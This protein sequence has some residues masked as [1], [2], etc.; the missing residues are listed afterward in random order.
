MNDSNTSNKTAHNASQPCVDSLRV[1]VSIFVRKGEQSLWENGIYQNCLFLVILLLRA[2]NVG[3]TYLV[4]GGGD[5]DI[6][7]AQRFMKDSPVPIIDMLTAANELDVMIEMSAQLDRNWAISFRE[8]GGK[9]VTMRVG[10][11]YVIDIERMIFDKPHGLLMAGTPYDEVWTLPEYAMTCAHYFGS[12]MRAPVRLMPHLWSSVVLDK[13]ARKLPDAQSFG[14]KPGRKKWRLGIFEPNICMVK[15]SHLAMLLI[16]LAHRANPRFIAQLQVYNTLNLKD[17]TSFVGFANSLDIVKHGLATFEGRFPV[18]Q[19]LSAQVDAVVSHQWENGQNY[20]YY[21][22]LHGGYPLIH[23]ST[24]IADCGYFY[25][26]FDCE[27]GGLATLQAYAQHDADLSNYRQKA[28][29][30]LQTLNPEYEDNIR[31]YNAA[32]VDLYRAEKLCS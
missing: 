22:V 6:N 7:D 11:D 13:A 23:N 12:A 17:Q 10:N 8:R 15:T 24:F 29:A 21:E 25:P 18:Y 28:Q 32:L 14:Y 3:K 2:P 31:L 30:F 27:Q 1:G 9:I 16:D 26:D 4:C 5:G 19:C 20:L